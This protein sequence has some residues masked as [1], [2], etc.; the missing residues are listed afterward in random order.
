MEPSI[1][2]LT[3]HHA[4]QVLTTYLAEATSI[5]WKMQHSLSEHPDMSRLSDMKEWAARLSVDAGI[6]AGAL[7]RISD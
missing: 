4:R 3:I 1:R 2:D 6:M 7:E 5:I